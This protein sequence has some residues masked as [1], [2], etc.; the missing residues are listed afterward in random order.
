MFSNPSAGGIAA[1]AA[2]SGTP[3]AQM[4]ALGWLMSPSIQQ[5]LGALST[6]AGS[7]TVDTTNTSD[8][9]NSKD[10]AMPDLAG[11]DPLNV[12]VA[13]SPLEKALTDV[14]NP[15]FI[16]PEMFRPCYS[17][18]HW[19]LPPITRLSM[20]ALHAQQNLLKHFPVIHEP[21]FRIDTTPACVAFAMCILGGHEAGRKW[22]AGE[23]VVP[24]SAINIIN[25]HSTSMPQPSNELQHLM[26]KV[27]GQYVDEEDGQELVKP[28]VMKDKTEMLMRTF[29][30]RCKSVRDKCS[31]VQAMMLFQGNN[32][33]S[34]DVTTRTV[35][36]VSH[37]TVVTL[38]RQAGFF[39]PD[40]E[41][42]LREVSYTADEVTQQ[43]MFE[44]VDTCFSY[45]FTSMYTPEAEDSEKIWRRWAELEGRRR[46]A[47]IIYT[48][49]TVAH[50]DAA[51]PTLL[52]TKEVAHLPLPSPDFIWRSPT[53]ASWSK[54]LDLYKGPT[55]DEALQQ[56][57]FV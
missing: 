14:K 19:A 8:Y 13:M 1:A 28:I 33:L 37:G 10:V 26:N 22:W 50:L 48:M 23:E 51:V 15:F 18:S 34:S 6:T 2:Q 3:G 16:P 21:T 41:H 29:A 31:V 17:I 4:S 53:A 27:P 43:V 9:F 12:E 38:A 11:A 40:A 35:A 46:S 56:L 47:F 42:A 20:L 55:L 44:L 30:S 5:L 32:F 36:D 7:G 49:D 52:A 45:S 25:S 24:K 57:L 54:A 39:E